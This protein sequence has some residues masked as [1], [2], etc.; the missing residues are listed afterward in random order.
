M[1]KLSNLNKIRTINLIFDYNSS[2]LVQKEY[3]KFD[4]VIANNVFNHSNDPVSFAKGANHILKSG[5]FYIFEVP[6]WKCSVESTK[7]DQIYHEHVS[8]FTGRSVK[9]IMELTGFQIDKIE[10]VDYHGGSLRVY[11]QKTKKGEIVHCDEL[12]KMISSEND[13]FSIAT[14]ENLMKDLSK[15]KI[16]F[17]HKLLTI[18]KSGGSI[19]AIG[20]AAKGNTLLNFLNL[21]SSLI[22]WVTDTSKFKHGKTTPLSNIEIFNYNVIGTYGKVYAL[23]LCWNLSCAIKTKLRKLNPRIEFINFYGNNDEE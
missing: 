23:I 1:T 9:E 4:V 15:R 22:D 12:Y 10:V 6:Y 11:A 16:H 3:G 18:K 7:I 5:G 19:V 17:K 13:L 14:Y 20:A 2:V 8:Y 21:D